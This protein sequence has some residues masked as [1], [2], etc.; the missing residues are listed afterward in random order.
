MTRLILHFLYIKYKP[1]KH[2]VIFFEVQKNADNVDPKVLKTKL[3][4]QCYHQNV[5]YVAVR[6]QYL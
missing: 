5:L 3:V 6:N 1:L 4:E 2:V